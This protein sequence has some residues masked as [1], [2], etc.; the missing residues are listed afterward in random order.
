MEPLPRLA[1][2][3]QNEIIDG[4]ELTPGVLN[5]KAGL[6]RRKAARTALTKENPNIACHS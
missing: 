5:T 1:P 6:Q 4:V 2:G 3:K